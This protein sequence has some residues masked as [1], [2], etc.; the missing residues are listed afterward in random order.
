MKI[1]E[2]N[3]ELLR[4]VAMLMVVLLHMNVF[5]LGGVNHDEVVNS[6]LTA[7]FRMFADQ[8]C[9][10]CVNVFI[11]ISGW[12]GIRPTLKGAMSIVY[13]VLFFTLI[14]FGFGKITGLETPV[15]KMIHVFDYGTAYWFISQYL[16]LYI[17]APA[18]NTFVEKADKKVIA[19]LL[20]GLFVFI[21]IFDW[22]VHYAN[23]NGGFSAIQFAGLYIL[24]RYLSSRCSLPERPARKWFLWYLIMT[25]IP[26]IIGFVGLYFIY[27]D[28][29]K[30]QYSSPFVVLASVFLMMGFSRLKIQSP[31]INWFACSAFAIY[32]IH[33]NPL[34]AP[35]F[36]SGMLQV[37]NWCGG[38]WYV[39]AA[40]VLA[41]LLGVVCILFD[42][43]RMVTWKW[44]CGLCLDNCFDK[45]S[46]AFVKIIR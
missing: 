29:G 42:K 20:S 16:L 35:W 1:R 38:A 31:V 18:L 5:V 27:F 26:V 40:V 25:I 23:L 28:L 8:L 34:S 14:L 6:P 13:Q 3:F 32:L 33:I 10:V 4:I 12:F 41:L 43:L 46:N 9:C 37:Y 39:L 17:L 45:I 2:S 15:S 36:K 30:A 11:L 21:F 24:A 7:G 22:N 44:L 19:S